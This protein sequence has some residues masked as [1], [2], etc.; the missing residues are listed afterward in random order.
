VGEVGERMRLA[1]VAVCL[2][3]LAACAGGPEIRS[4]QA[5]PALAAPVAPRPVQQYPLPDN[6]SG[7]NNTR[8]VPESLKTF[9]G[10]HKAGDVILQYER[11]WVRTARLTEDYSVPGHDSLILPKGTPLRAALFM[12]IRQATPT[13]SKY[14]PPNDWN[15]CADTSVERSVCFAWFSPGKVRAGWA[16]GGSVSMRDP[17]TKVDAPEPVFVEEAITIPNVI[18][19]LTLDRIQSDGVVYRHAQGDGGANVYSW[20]TPHLE[21]GKPWSGFGQNDQVVVTA[22][23]VRSA[24]GAIVAATVTV[25]PNP[26]ALVDR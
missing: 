22:S 13:G 12:Y 10:E 3:V 6:W 19:Q 11:S 14:P 2:A 23:P 8:L 26:D 5:A 4:V 21:W 1:P 15:W 18:H 24:D 20:V 16:T 9:A 25:T 7:P 17:A